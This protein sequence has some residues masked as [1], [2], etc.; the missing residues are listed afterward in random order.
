MNPS[1][2]VKAGYGIAETGITASEVLIRLYLLIFYTDIVGL[3]PRLAGYA[4]ALAIVWDAI[5][6]P[7]MGM[8]S[9][10]T[11]SRFGRRRP[12]IA[13]G[14]VF[15]GASL[16]L[17]FN[18]P[19]LDTQTG[20]FLFLLGSYM[21][22]NTAMTVISIPHAALGS[23]LTP[24][25]N[26]VT[27]IYA[28]RLVSGNIGAI[29]GT[30]VPG[31]IL[32]QLGDGSA[33][34]KASAHV[35]AAGFI[36]VIIVVTAAICFLATRGADKP[37]P[38]HASASFNIKEPKADHKR[39]GYLGGIKSLLRNKPFITLF[40]AYLIATVGVNINSSFAFY[41]YKY[42]LQLGEADTQKIIAFFMVVFTIGLIGWITV[43]NRFGK[44]WPLF[45]GTAGLGIMT[46]TGYPLFQPGSL[47]GPAIAG[48]LGGIFV[49]SI[50]LLDA[51][52]VDVVD[53][54]EVK[55]G[56]NRAGLYF[57]IWKMGAKAARALAVA[58]SGIIL[59]AIGFQPNTTQTDEVSWRIAL[60]FGPGVAFFFIAGA[61]LSLG[62]R[63][64][65]NQVVKVRR[66]LERR[67][68]RATSGRKQ[69]G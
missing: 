38:D 18:P 65:D 16:V 40:A 66:I 43:A 37:G 13:A 44:K 54:D 51:W 45:A 22:L 9:D 19:Q 33:T 31:I 59:S 36:G 48:I 53:Y 56:S 47:A 64:D 15:L 46:A 60:V 61:L 30:V 17:L 27:E 67:R 10:H 21:L 26:Q 23:E 49:G 6:D 3:E 11:R 2:A 1:R 20:K 42:R 55:Y 41:Y 35:A 50:L 34:A 62:M 63:L 68:A 8:I 57:G 24:D 52:L 69:V 12:Y 29:L 28:W 4:A 7:L 5:T 39:K 14:A 32:V 25:R 58:F